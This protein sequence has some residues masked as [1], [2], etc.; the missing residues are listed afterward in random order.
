MNN[1]RLSLSL[2]GLVLCF[3]CEDKLELEPEQTLSTDA[4]FA[5]ELSSQGSLIGVY[6]KAQDLEVFGSM[7]QV[8]AEYQSD[9]V[10]FIGSFPTLQEINNYTTLADNASIEGIWRDNY[11]LIL[12][13]NAVIT[14]VPDVEDPGFTEDEK[15]QFVREAKF[16]RA[17]TYF[18]MVNLFAYSYPQ[19]DGSNPGV[20]LVLDPFEGEVVFPER[21]T[22]DQVHAQ[23][24]QDLTDA[25][26][27]PASYEDGVL[28]RARATQGAA[29]ALLSRL[30]LYRGEWQLAADYAR[31]VIDSDVYGL[32]ANYGFYSQNTAEEIF[33]LQNSATD[34]GR[35]GSGG[36][37]S[38][39]NPAEE[40]GRGDAPYAQDLIDAYLEEEGDLRF[41][42]LT[43]VN[44]DSSR[45]YT[46]KFPDATTNADNIPLIRITE[47]YLN[48]AEALAELN[49][50]NEESLGLINDLRARAGLPAFTAGEFGSTAEFI[51]AIL[52]E[53]R[54]ELAFEGHRRMDLL[55]RGLALRTSGATADQADPGDPKTILNIPQR[56]LDI[57]P[58]L[59]QNPGY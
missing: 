21:A 45:L 24:Q 38:Y 5:D 22:L 58:N 6:S 33:S 16:M 23:I 35:T 40:G 18:Q 46:T 4:A 30:H 28:T 8:I 20:P 3:A 1:I 34:N 53:R 48:R 26:D 14:N 29:Q 9:N 37:A 43:Q 57:N 41:L 56:E 2:A 47:M 10:N 25:I 7:P 39:Y 49:G 12:T 19:A 27:L 52:N 11:E 59:S 54:K 31:A 55:R 50:V 32:A 36:W 44:A 42:S 15:N 17:M 13:A 51:A